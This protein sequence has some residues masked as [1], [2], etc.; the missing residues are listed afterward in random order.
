MRNLHLCTHPIGQ[1]R[2]VNTSEVAPN[3]LDIV[4]DKDDPTVCHVLQIDKTEIKAGDVF[5]TNAYF[6][7]GSGSGNTYIVVA[8]SDN[9][10][11]IGFI[12]INNM[13]ETTNCQDEIKD[14]GEL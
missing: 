14:R 10:P 11:N 8:S 5:K 6:E 2:I 9:I 13:N 7:D 1:C 3:G 4:Q 12:E